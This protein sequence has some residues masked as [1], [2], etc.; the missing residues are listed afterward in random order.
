M[1]WLDRT[2]EYLAPGWALARERARAGMAMVRHY[3]AAAVGRRTSGWNRATGDANAVVGSATRT[4][5]AVARDLVRNNAH[6]RRG[7]KT[8]AN[9]T[10]GWGIVPKT[11]DRR[12]DEL[13]KA[14]AE[15]T[16]CDADGRN[17]F[18]GLQK[19]V[20]RTVAESGEVL[21][22]RRMRRPED[23]LPLPLQI[24]VIEADYL[25]TDRTGVELQNG[26][27]IINGVEFD[28]IGRR[29]AY[30]LF[31]EHP[32]AQFFG[33]GYNSVR[34]PAEG[35]A[36]VYYQ[37]R[38][39]QVRGMSWLASIILMLKDY[40]EYVDA[41]LLKQKI[42][43]YL[44]VIMTDP[45]G[46][47]PAFGRSEDQDTT[48]PA[49]DKIKPGAVIYGAP[50]AEATIVQPPRV[51][52]F[53]DY[54]STTLHSIAAGMDVSYED[55]TGNYA[56]VNFS[57]ARMS[58]L[59]HWDCVHDWRWQMLIPQ[60][61]DPVWRWAMDAAIIMNLLDVIPPVQ[62]T[63]PPMP[64]IEPDKEGLAYQRN[65]RTGIMSLSEALRERGY[66][67]RE[68]LREIAEDNK[69]LDRYELVLDCDA[70]KTT[71][72]GQLQ[73]AA[74]AKEEPAGAGGGGQTDD[75][76]PA[77]GAPVDEDEEDEA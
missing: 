72:A 60:M 5:R 18:Y 69:M 35:I 19:L 14:W 65:I 6:A 27:R 1:R 3:E 61:C 42:A 57:S 53:T 7:V 31:K 70:R 39:G 62:W 73:A 32:G 2:I 77:A 38:P 10:V 76:K 56:E 68:M 41:Q 74:P 17:D 51:G 44:A 13:W 49:V 40:D 11:K 54:A 26:G 23:G 46:Q 45:T 71:Q 37:E 66:D 75:E 67:P 47:S 48:L 24:Q 43:A 9:H 28:A 8:I 21:I 30:W 55:L 36:H 15:T 52:E 29:V 33:G 22:R 50:G 63:P 20:T 64:M 25:D 4:V 59:S 58:R 34:V 12:A 16:A